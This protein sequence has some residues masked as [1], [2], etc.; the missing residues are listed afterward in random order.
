[1]FGLATSEAACKMRIAE[2]GCCRVT[3]QLFSH[4]GIGIRVVAAGE[5]LLLTEEAFSTTDREPATV[6]Y[7]A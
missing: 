4:P 1:M 5:Q 2:G 3:K 6:T 7:F